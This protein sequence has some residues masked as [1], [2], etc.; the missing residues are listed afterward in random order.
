MIVTDRFVF[1]HLHKSGG[2]FV[3]SFLQQFESSAKMI[4]YHLPYRELPD[5]YHQLPVLG[6]VRN[7][8]SYYVSW[9]SFQ[10]AMESPNPLFRIVSDNR[11][12]DFNAT[13]TNLVN[14]SES[15]ARLDALQQSLPDHFRPRGLNL[16][17]ACIEPLRND[18]IGFYSFMYERM[19]TGSREPR[20]VTMESLREELLDALPA[21]GRELSDEE[22]RYIEQQPPTNTTRHGPFQDYYSDELRAL[23]ADKD[24][25]VIERF[26]YSFP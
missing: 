16:T 24:R 8:W 2:T 19:Y 10:A 13:I 26:G 22:Q 7:P 4:G 9:Y 15:P 25:A 3:L 1:I 5:E 20:I 6:S 11:Q 18:N 14:L 17:R 21:C 12:L 23:I